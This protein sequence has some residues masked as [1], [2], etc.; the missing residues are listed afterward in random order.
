[1]YLKNKL[2]NK[3]TIKIFFN[4]MEKK[5][6]LF[7]GNCNMHCIQETLKTCDFIKYYNL[8]CYSTH[9]THTEEEINKFFEELKHF[10]VI[11][12]QPHYSEPIYSIDN[13]VSHT[14]SD[15][16]V[17]ILSV[18]Y[19]NFYYPNLIYKKNTKD[20]MC[21]LPSH[22]HDKLLIKLYNE[23]NENIEN[24]FLENINNENFFEKTYLENLANNSISELERRENIFI[25][26]KYICERNY[27]F[28][29]LSNFI[30]KNYKKK[31]LFYSMNH[32]TYYLFEYIC[33][34]ILKILNLKKLQNTFEKID[35]LYEN[36]RGILY[37][38]IQK[39]VNFNINEHKPSINNSSNI[40][41]IINMYITEYK[42]D[43]KDI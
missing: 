42:K 18:A 10:S 36:D 8:F 15:C 25:N 23:N 32:P 17:I 7:F 16:H 11:I 1:M 41:E 43:K 14:N 12:L 21:V 33:N 35:L 2:C 40:N 28:I 9:L 26:L 4:Y 20:E 3:N 30:K 27:K 24:S 6:C 31:L 29:T 39:C 38:S 34:E 13:I 19:F 5:N 37:K 22:Y